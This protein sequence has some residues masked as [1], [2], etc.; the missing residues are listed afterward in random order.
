M[1]TETVNVTPELALK[2]LGTMK[3]NRRVKPQVVAQYAKDMQD[4]NWELTHQGIAFNTLNELNDGQHRL[5]AITQAGVTVPLQVT[6]GVDKPEVFDTG[7]NRNITDAVTYKP[8]WTG[9]GKEQAAI[10]KILQLGAGGIKKRLSNNQVADTYEKY[11]EG[12][13]FACAN[14]KNIRNIKGVT[15]P[16]RAVV[17]RAYYSQNKARLLEFCNVLASGVPLN[18]GDLAALRLREKLQDI[19]REQKYYYTQAALAAFLK[20]KSL[21][22][23]SSITE[24]LFALPF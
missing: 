10:A 20:K 19:A 13:D 1:R 11:K 4:G 3:V 23:L 8:E 16:V 12:I 15:S 2:Y 14:C 22:N 18:S 17:A 9:L 24:E 6:Y 21:K 7:A 5:L